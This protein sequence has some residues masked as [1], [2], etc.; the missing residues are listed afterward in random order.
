M[1][2]NFSFS[3]NNYAYMFPFQVFR[4]AS[5][6][7]RWKSFFRLTET[8]I[9]PPTNE[10]WKKSN[11]EWR[12]C[13]N[14][15]RIHNREKTLW[16][17]YQKFNHFSIGI[18]LFDLYYIKYVPFFICFAR[19]SCKWFELRVCNILP[20]IFFPVI[21]Q[22]PCFFFVSNTSIDVVLRLMIWRIFPGSRE[23]EEKNKDSQHLIA[24]RI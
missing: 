3:V 1:D 7:S 6:I 19:F 16:E 10:H 18:L 11:V 24:Y 12:Q 9:K 17:T 15:V 14:T 2:G 5:Y 13:L 8:K 21:I 20:V 23:S 4:V 22:C